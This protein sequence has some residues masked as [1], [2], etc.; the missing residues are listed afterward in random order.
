MLSDD[1]LSLRQD[2]QHQEQALAASV[3]QNESRKEKFQAQV[4]E[5]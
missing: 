1:N 4:R 5:F 3:I 2:L